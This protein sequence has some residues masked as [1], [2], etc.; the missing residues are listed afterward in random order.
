MNNKKLRELYNVCNVLLNSESC[1]SP[2]K[3][4]RKSWLIIELFT[5]KYRDIRCGQVNFASSWGLSSTVSP[6]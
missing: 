4:F 2:L 5:Y 1:G 6:N 3:D